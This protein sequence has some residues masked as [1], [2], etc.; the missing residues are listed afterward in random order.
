MDL[1]RASQ[2]PIQELTAI[3]NRSRSDY[4]VPMPMTVWQFAEYIRVYDIDL[5]ASCVARGDN[6]PLGLCMTGIRRSS[7]WITRL[8]VIPEFRRRGVGR[9]MVTHCLGHLAERDVITVQLE[10]ISG[11]HPA[12]L[13]F[14]T[15]GFVETQPLSVLRRPP[16]QPSPR[17]S[18]PADRPVWLDTS[19]VLKALKEAGPARPWINQPESL[20]NAGGVQGLHLQHTDPA[21][22]WLSFI[23]SGSELAH[24]DLWAAA[25]PDAEIAHRLLD[26]LHR[27]FPALSATAE[28]ILADAPV[29]TVLL[30]HN[31]HEQ[32]SRIEMKLDL[33][34]Q[35]PQKTSC[36]DPC[37]HE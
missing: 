19:Q 24:V 32:F 1:R 13:M 15:F 5:D 7:A 10:V 8:G 33:A 25:S 31:Y 34:A 6:A 14:R 36:S 23:R 12:L 11:N 28:N 9:S 4:I 37:S 3:Y 27:R 2:F 20:S 29:L 18:Q 22:G 35:T 16:C 21:S 17:Q 30:A 26:Q